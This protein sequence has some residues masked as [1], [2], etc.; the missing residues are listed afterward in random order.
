MLNTTR[1]IGCGLCSYV[2]PSRVEISDFVYS[3]K[4]YVDSFAEIKSTEK[5]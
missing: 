2:C 5:K 1:C 3:A 4:D